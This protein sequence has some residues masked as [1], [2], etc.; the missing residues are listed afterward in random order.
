MERDF[1]GCNFLASL[2]HIELQA[3]AP[4]ALQVPFVNTQR[5]SLGED[6]HLGHSYVNY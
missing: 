6:S 5:R 2:P 1:S 4:E 3:K